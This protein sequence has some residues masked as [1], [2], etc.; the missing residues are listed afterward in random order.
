MQLLYRVVRGGISL[1]M[2]LL[3]HHR[4][5]GIDHLPSGRALLAANHASFLDPPIVACSSPKEVHFLARSSLFRHPFFRCIISSLNAHPL[6]GS[7]QD[8]KLFHS[9]SKLLADEQ[10]IL[11]FPE[12]SRSA[13]GR[14][15]PIKNGAALLSLRCNSPIVPIYI[16]GTYQAWPRQ[17]WLPRFNVETAC[18]FGT[19]LDPHQFGSLE[20]KEAQQQLSLALGAAIGRLRSWYLDGATGSPP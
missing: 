13:D 4:T 1:F 15:C 10:H 5:F 14:L 6:A 9:V 18:V 11:L 2:R 8:A 16:H 12:G 20:K 17:R 19:P 7:A 3:Y